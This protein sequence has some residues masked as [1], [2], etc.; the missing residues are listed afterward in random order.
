[1]RLGKYAES[2]R[3]AAGP[4]SRD[5]ERQRCRRNR[6]MVSGRSSHGFCDGSH[7][8]PNSLYFEVY[9]QSILSTLI[10]HPSVQLGSQFLRIFGLFLQF[11]SFEGRCGLRA[12]G[13]MADW[14]PVNLDSYYLSTLW[15]QWK[16]Y[17]CG[18]D[19]N[20]LP[21]LNLS[22]NFAVSSHPTLSLTSRI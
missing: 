12:C 3:S 5:L 1:M 7:L 22:L 9:T 2:A 18:R 11:F 16:V 20:F 13:R 4:L 8:R 10:S 14:F 17:F 15:P 19:D 21:P 6:E